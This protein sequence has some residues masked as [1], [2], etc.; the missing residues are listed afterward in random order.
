MLKY[1][2][3]C[4]RFVKSLAYSLSNKKAYPHL[5]DGE[6]GSMKQR[7]FASWLKY[8]VSFFYELNID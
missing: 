8:Y 6:V 1:I 4:V 7:N 3:D 5:T 2:M